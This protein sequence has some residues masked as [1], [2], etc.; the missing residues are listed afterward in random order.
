ME[1]FLPSYY[2]DFRC[3]AD[4]CRHSCCVG[5]EISV[6]DETMEKYEVLGEDVLCHIEDGEIILCDDERCP[7]LRADGLCHM[8]CRHGEEYTSVICREHPRFYH[9]VGDRVEGGIGA[10]CEEACRII[11]LSDAFDELISLDW[12]GEIADET[13]FDTLPYRQ[14]IYEI[15]HSPVPYGEMIEKIRL[16]FNIENCISDENVCEL[17]E[18]L[19]YL[20]EE[21]R[22]LFRMGAC[23]ERSDYEKYYRRFLAYL[24]FRHMSIAD[25][26][27]N[28]R[29]VIAFCLMLVSLLRSMS[30]GLEFADLCEMARIISEEIEY[31]LDN[32]SSL[33]FEFETRL[34]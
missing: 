34:I 14:K 31:S 23:D 22:A 33:I 3:I 17:F 27:D 29:A 24:I 13:D 12:C 11:L 28:M 30:Y 18:G 10:S 5:W 16:E 25:S 1:I 4:R 15:L 7:F 20:N 26:Y 2:K 8:I 6:D 9:R 32:T 19:E 21:H